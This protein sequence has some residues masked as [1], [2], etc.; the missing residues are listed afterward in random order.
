MFGFSGFLFACGLVLMI[1]CVLAPLD[2]QVTKGPHP[3]RFI[4]YYLIPLLYCLLE[5][6]FYL[7]GEAVDQPHVIY[8]HG[9]WFTRSWEDVFKWLPIVV[10]GVVILVALDQ[11]AQPTDEPDIGYYPRIANLRLAVCHPFV[12]LFLVISL[13]LIAYYYAIT[14]LE[15][16]KNEQR[17]ALVWPPKRVYVACHLLWGTLWFADCLV[18]TNRG[19]I[20]AA[21]VYLV[22]S[23][24]SLNFDVL[25]E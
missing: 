8:A 5:T 21:T 24:L 25:R 16:W 13:L 7:L 22:F 2:R 17:A 19:T 10:I 23:W 12:R 6:A 4:A 9:D 18:R 1:V 20:R 3:V 14:V 11:A 15:V